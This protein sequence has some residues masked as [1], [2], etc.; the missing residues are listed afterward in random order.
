[1]FLLTRVYTK[2]TMIEEELK[3]HKCRWDLL[4]EH[5]WRCTNK[6]SASHGITTTEGCLGIEDCFEPWPV[7]DLIGIRI[8]EETT[9]L[10]NKVKRL[11]K[12]VEDLLAEAHPCRHW[13]RR[14]E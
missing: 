7:M 12:I 3:I 10:W 8:E 6:A 1:M 13:K 4:T 14:K 11:E 5:G 9:L 2:Y